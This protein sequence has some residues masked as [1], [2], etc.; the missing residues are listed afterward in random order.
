[1]R[2]KQ[3]RTRPRQNRE[4]VSAAVTEHLAEQIDRRAE[5]AGCSRCAWIRN[6]LTAAVQEG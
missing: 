2:V 5:E 4:I 6:V 1:M 3:T